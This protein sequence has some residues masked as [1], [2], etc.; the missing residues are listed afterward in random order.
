MLY[1]VNVRA[2]VALGPKDGSQVPE[3]PA[4][5][6][7]WE[8]YD[9]EEREDGGRILRFDV[10]V[11]VEAPDAREAMAEAE[12]RAPLLVIPGEALDVNAHPEAAPRI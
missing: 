7:P 6:S 11:T 3:A 5:D 1:D 9:S 8:C 4:G 12:A 10:L 2:I